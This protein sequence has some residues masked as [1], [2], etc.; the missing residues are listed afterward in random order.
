VEGVRAEKLVEDYASC[1]QPVV[2]VVLVVHIAEFVTAH[3]LT[4]Q[5]I[6]FALEP[7]AAPLLPERCG[8][9][10]GGLEAVP[11]LGLD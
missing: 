9:H 10:D 8:L 4:P 7:A 1:R 2:T 5:T 11:C 6:V 3:A